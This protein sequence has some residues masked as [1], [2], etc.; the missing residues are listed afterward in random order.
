MNSIIERIRIFPAKG[1][2]GIELTEGHL[3]KDLGLEGD[4]NA[5]GGERQVSLRFLESS[6]QEVN[7]VEKGLCLN[8]FRENLTIRCQSPVFRF[9][10]G[11]AVLEISGETKHCYEDCELFKEGKQCSLKSQCFFAKVVESGVVRIGDKIEL[12]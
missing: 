9:A 12:L 5:K 4:H 11:Q 6:F 8:R 10:A 1:Q 3:V 7:P 2:A